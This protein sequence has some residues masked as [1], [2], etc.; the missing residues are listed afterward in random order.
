MRG[1]IIKRRSLS[2][3]KRLVKVKTREGGGKERGERVNGCYVG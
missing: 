1:D 3:N 2:H